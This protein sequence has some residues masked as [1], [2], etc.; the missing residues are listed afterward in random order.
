METLSKEYVGLTMSIDA[1]NITDVAEGIRH[2]KDAIDLFRGAI[3]LL[4][5]VSGILPKG[6]KREAAEKALKEA[7]TSVRIAEAKLA[8]GLGYELCHCKFPPTPMLRVGHSRRA[9]ALLPVFEC[10]ICAQNS[11]MGHSF[12]R[13]VPFREDVL[14]YQGQPPSPARRYN[15]PAT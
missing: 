13:M 3:G 1:N 14:H 12:F 5:E 6:S 2:A 11:A 8:K 9:G 15:E 4:K 10:P 7:E